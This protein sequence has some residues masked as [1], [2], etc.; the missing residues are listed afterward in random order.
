VNA[1]KTDATGLPMFNTYNDIEMKDSIDFLT[2][3]VDPRLDHTV[4][5][6]GHPYKYSGSFIYKSSWARTP[7]IYGPYSTMK[8]MLRPDDPGLR[9]VGAF[10]GTAKN[11]DIIR[12]ADVLL[13]KAEALIELGRE[14]E[15]LPLIN[16]LRT[17]AQNSTT[18]LKKADGSF[19]SNYRV[20]TYL[21]GV[22]CVWTQ[23]FARK[24]MQWERRMEFAME[25]PRFFDLVRW[26]IAAETL[27][28]YLGVEKKRH[29]Y[30]QNAQF[31]KGK[32]EY[33]PVP[34]AQID[35]TE[36]IYKQNNGW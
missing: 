19:S 2:N 27:N 25:S 26:G 18:K 5:I 9:K 20:N 15:A 22:N 28:L 6:P 34:Q 17:R 30:L 32:D 8:E 33:L 7:T 1:F 24:A 16:M 36:G 10:F 13:W 21:D 14:K 12:Y 31:T 29:S 35:L 3:G 4:G 11:A 23:D